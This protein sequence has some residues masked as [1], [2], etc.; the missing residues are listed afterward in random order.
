MALRLALVIDGDPAGAKKA[1]DETARG[2]EELGVKA[3]RTGKRFEWLPAAGDDARKVA[4]PIKAV[5]DGLKATEIAAPGAAAGIADIGKAAD[6]SAG[7]I[8]ALRGAVV[9]VATGLAAGLAASALAAGLEAAA[10]AAGSFLRELIDN[11][12]AAERALAAHED[13]VKRIKGAYGEA[14]GAASSYGRES[15]NVLTFQGQG[16]V[17][18]LEGTFRG[19]LQDIDLGQGFDVAERLGRRMGPDQP[20]VQAVRQFRDD[21]KDGI[22]DVIAFRDRIASEAAGLAEDSPFRVLA[23][24]MLSATE[25]SARLQEELQRSIDLYKGLAGDS[26]A[27]ATALGGS[28]EK[29]RLAGEAAAGA[30]PFLRETDAILKS[31]GAGAGTVDRSALPGAPPGVPGG[32]FAAGGF[33]GHLPAD[34]I[35]GVVHG[36]EYVFDAAATARIGV[37]NLEAIRGGVRGY[38]TGGA[39]DP[40]AGILPADGAGFA[41]A[42]MIARDVNILSGAVSQFVSELRNGKTVLEALGSV[43]QR[44][45]DRFLDMAVNALDRVVFGGFTGGAA[46]GGLGLLSSLFGGGTSYFPPAPVGF[47]TLHGG[48]IVGRNSSGTRFAPASVFAGAPRLHSGGWL[49]PGERPV[50]A[51]DGEEVG[52]PDQ[53][54][55]KYGRAAGG[56]VQNFYVETP[57]PRA[58]AESRATTARA[59]S[60]FMSRL[61]RYS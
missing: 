38:A 20:I 3:E 5:G 32:S 14:R 24:Q 54:A 61:G 42:G 25:E 49:K 13:L 48:G 28:A 15:R 31:I 30:L 58:F 39:V 22:A 21:L 6:A 60:R 53:L 57:S 8:G 34:R 18:R 35:A 19:S 29:L 45:S 59:G 46:S 17:R 27:A 2:V 55:K 50:I 9:G 56:V 43:I 1:L 10:G 51:M 16:N 47:H 4:E 12:P 40:I 23:E 11:S 33:T 44:V 7:R 26:E 37:A 36:G 52:W 41:A